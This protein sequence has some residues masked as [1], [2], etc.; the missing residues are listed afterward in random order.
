M[1]VQFIGWPRQSLTA[2]VVC[3]RNV[4]K[5]NWSWPADECLRLILCPG[6]KSTS[7][8]KGTALLCCSAGQLFLRQ[9]CSRAFGI[10][11]LNLHVDALRLL[12]VGG[13]IHLSQLQLSFT[14]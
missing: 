9:T 4:Q 8:L 2:P 1:P 14:L 7:N 3:R 11:L 5:R 6:D 12:G 10:F 13:L